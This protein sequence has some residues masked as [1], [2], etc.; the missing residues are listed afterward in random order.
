[1]SSGHM[2]DREPKKTTTI[3]VRVSDE[4]KAA[5]LER[6]RET[7]RSASDALREFMAGYV[8]A[9][10]EPCPSLIEKGWTLMK[11]PV[12]GISALAGVVLASTAL[13]FSPATAIADD[14][15]LM[16]EVSISKPG[17]NQQVESAIN[18]DYGRAEQFRLPPSFDDEGSYFYE[19]GVLASPCEPADRCAADNVIVEVTITRHGEEGEQVIASPVLLTKYGRGAVMS[20]RAA[21]ALN[22]R[23]EI[24]AERVRMGPDEPEG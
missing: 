3:E 8:R 10:S 17:D 24:H 19:V 1:M 9:G 20:V 18:L 5:F 12:F 7:G 15:E 11:K 4:A 2:Q 16:F 22:V 6:C 13:L 14:V 21:E 23:V